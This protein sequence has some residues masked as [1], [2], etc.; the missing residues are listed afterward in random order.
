[1]RVAV[2][3]F[4]P[5]FGEVGA[6]LDTVDRM[7]ESVRADVIVL[8]E[9]F[10]TGYLFTSRDELPRLAESLDGPTVTRIQRWARR[11]DA[12]IVAG[13]AE[14]TPEGCYN[15]AVVIGPEGLLAHYRK[16]HLFDREKLW[17]EPGNLGFPVCEFRG[18]RLGVMVCF[19]WRFPEA[20]RSLAFKGAD[21]IVHPS[22]LVLPWCPDAMITRALENNVFI[23][24][25]DR[26]GT[27]ERGGTRLRFIGRSQVVDPH[28]RR[29]A[30]LGEDEDG[31][32]TVDIDPASARNKQVNEHNHLFDDLRPDHYLGGPV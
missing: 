6:N 4:A 30:Q 8:P 12:A 25:S 22:N 26:W 11:S 18:A 27:D 19:D 2:L 16:I 28:G 15:S 21:L 1:M 14:A 20:A 7:L 24:T 31:V 32:L 10:Q 23:A 5:R 13:I 3:Q 17:F 9:L 29:L